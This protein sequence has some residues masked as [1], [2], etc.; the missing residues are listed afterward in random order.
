MPT[1][2]PMSPPTRHAVYFAPSEDHPL[3]PLGCTW[4]GFNPRG[5]ALLPGN[6]R[7]GTAA[8]RR[9]GFHA[10]LKAPMALRAGADEAEFMDAVATLAARHPPFTVPTLQVSLRDGFLALRPVTDPSADHPLRRL[11]D[12]CV[13][14]LDEWRA[15]LEAAERARRLGSNADARRQANVDRHGYAHVLDDWH[16]HLTLTEPLGGPPTD[17]EARLDEAARWF[18]PALAVPLACDAIC[19]AVEPKRGAPFELRHRFRLGAGGLVPI[20]SDRR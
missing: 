10:T 15:P 5:G 17:A 6:F 11:A 7:D 9:Y 8:P 16:F 12:D 2:T 18:A 3:W 19:V 13:I 4:L 14:G 20:G 1:P